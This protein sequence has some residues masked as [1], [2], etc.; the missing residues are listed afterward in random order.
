LVMAKKNV[1]RSLMIT[2]KKFYRGEMTLQEEKLFFVI[3]S[4]GVAN[5]PYFS[6]VRPGIECGLDYIHSS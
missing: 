6:E 5:H 4:D 2:K 1:A 3:E